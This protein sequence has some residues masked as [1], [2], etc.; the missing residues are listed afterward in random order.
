MGHYDNQ[1]DMFKQRAEKNKR[2]GDRY[3]AL[4]KSAKES[5]D[6]KAAE[7]Y[8]AQ[9]QHQYKSQKENESKAKEHEGKTW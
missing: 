5:G 7:K 1:S 9:A 2:D 6:D 3:Y 8:M 4:S